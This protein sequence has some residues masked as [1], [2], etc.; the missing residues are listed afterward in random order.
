MENFKRCQLNDAGGS[1]SKRWFVYYFFRN[2]D[3]SKFVRFRQWIPSKILT[4]TGRRDYAY[5]LKKQ[6]D[7]KLAEGFNP[8]ANVEKKYSSIIFAMDKILEVKK[9][10]CRPRSYHTYKT[11]VKSFKQ[12]LTEN[13]LDKLPIGDFNYYHAQ[14]F[15]DWSK[16]K[17]GIANI[18]YNYRL[19]HMKTFFNMLVEREWIFFNPFLK[20][21]KLPQADTE[22]KAFTSKELELLENNLPALDFD[23][24]VIC[25]LI[26]YCFLRPAEIMRLKFE[27]FYL[28]AKR[29]TLPGTISKNKRSET[30]QIPNAMMPVLQKV[31][32]NFPSNYLL[33]SR[34]LKPGM[35]E[36]APTRIAG[37][38][39]EFADV[40]GIPKNIYSLKHTGIGM[41]L[42]AGIN[43]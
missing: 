6:I 11:M 14:E 1:L 25:C 3:T 41:A 16:T 22:I 9:G 12:F 39:R 32:W 24:Y 37:R 30:V 10:Y 2:P 27:Y 26:F 23:L 18:T 20:V 8:Y 40:F 36:A 29:I 35:N 38:W 33:F 17:L 7:K 19:M 4:A 21:K 31:N 34:H 15:M 42:E 13:K 28:S 5:T 43:L